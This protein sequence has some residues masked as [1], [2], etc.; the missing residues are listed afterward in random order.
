MAFYPGRSLASQPPAHVLAVKPRPGL[1][2]RVL[3]D[4]EIQFFMTYGYLKVPGCFTRLQCEM[5]MGDLWTRM[6]VTP[7]KR[8]WHSERID[9]PARQDIKLCELSPKTWNVICALLRGE[10]RTEE[11]CH[12]WEDSL[13]VNLGIPEKE[14][15]FIHGIDLEGWHVDGDNF[16]HFL[17]SPEMG[18]LMIPLFTDVMPNSGGTALCPRALSEIA[19]FLYCHPEGMGV[20]SSSD[21][22]DL[23]IP[24]YRCIA[25]PG[26]SSRRP[27]L[28]PH[29]N[30][31]AGW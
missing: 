24:Y 5:I 11:W 1:Q 10:E 2:P 9:V 23:T 29:A 17:D 21:A 6:G 8:T 31:M 16:C 28:E 12:T 25:R 20:C 14:G 3:Q 22:T 30:K 13:I 19:H 27:E 18:L 7:D 15:K 26:T 4:H